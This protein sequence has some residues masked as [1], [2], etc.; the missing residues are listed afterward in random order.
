MSP[1]SDSDALLQSLD[2]AI[3]GGT[4]PVH[5]LDDR[6]YVKAHRAFEQS[7]PQQAQI[8]HRLE[9]EARQLIEAGRGPLNV[10]SVGCGCGML[11]HSLLVHLTEHVE[12][13]VGVDPNPAA[14]AHFRQTL[15]SK[16]PLPPTRI[17][18]TRFEDLQSDRRYDFIYC[19]HVFYYVEDRVSTFQRMCSQLRDGG[20]LVIAHAPKTAM[21][22]LAQVF[23]SEHQQ[24][25]FFDDDLHQLIKTHWPSPPAT[26]DISAGIP[27]TLF[28]DNTSQ[29]TL[30]LE[31][32]LQAEWAPL[33]SPV[34]DQVQSYIDRHTQSVPGGRAV[35]PH[36][37]TTF[38]LRHG[39]PS[40]SGSSG[41]K[42]AE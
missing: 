26:H 19:S 23:W 41:A 29:G 18:C 16:R 40:R 10:L 30:L 15:S 33:P 42:N 20:T 35:L 7:S 27:R 25:D 24:A 28:S 17:E 32:L 9:A 11:D 21:N 3:R 22:A 39:T 37:V 1:P 13:F 2:D 8:R 31:F 34:Q 4:V 36:P 6:R 38:A 5:A 14:V 12:S